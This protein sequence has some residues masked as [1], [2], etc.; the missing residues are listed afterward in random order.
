MTIQSEI[1][2]KLSRYQP[3][4]PDKTNVSP[5]LASIM[6][7]QNMKKYADEKIKQTYKE[8]VSEK[9]IPSDDEV[10]QNGESEK[11][12]LSSPS[13]KLIYK[14]SAPRKSFDKDLFIERV[15][16]ELGVSKLKLKKIAEE[17]VKH[18]IPPLTKT[19]IESA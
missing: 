7:Y 10:R 14:L 1:H 9:L 3:I 2:R 17:S 11:V 15:A 5:Y 6:Y 19:V 16:T 18:S 4:N 12:I 8:L 13:F